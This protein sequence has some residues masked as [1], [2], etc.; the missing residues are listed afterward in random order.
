MRNLNRLL[1]VLTA[2]QQLGAHRR[3]LA[4]IALDLAEDIHA[5]DEAAFIAL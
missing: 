1:V 2:A 4:R 5:G 3:E